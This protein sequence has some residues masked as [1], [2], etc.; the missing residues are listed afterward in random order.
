MLQCDL[1]RPLVF[2]MRGDVPDAGECSLRHR[3][4][5]TSEPYALGIPQDGA[6]RH[7]AQVGD[8]RTLWLM[9]SEPVSREP[10]T[11]DSRAYQPGVHIPGP[12]VPINVESIAVVTASV[13]FGKAFFE[14]LGQRAGSSV[15]NLPKQAS[16][17]IHRR[18]K[19]EDQP[20]EIHIGANGEST[21]TI[22]ITA[23]TPD[24]ARLTLLD[25]DVTAEDLRGKIL[26][27]DNEAKAW[28]PDG[29]ED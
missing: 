6:A 2:G 29:A 27:W 19:R 7:L 23:S 22:V 26:R 1:L 17:L 3:S 20:D 18:I 24:E 12:L 9:N 25:L 16:D 5:T 13:V 14:T 10:E 4:M 15:A 21:A 28:R 8:H 11:E